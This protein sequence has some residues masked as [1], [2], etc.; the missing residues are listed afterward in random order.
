MTA[1]DLAALAQL[2][3]ILGLVAIFVGLVIRAGLR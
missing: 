2:L 3:P 1:A